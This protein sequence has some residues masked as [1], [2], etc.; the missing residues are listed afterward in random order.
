M[1][2]TLVRWY[3]GDR[4]LLGAALATLAVGWALAFAWAPPDRFQGDVQRL[5]YVHVPAAWSALALFTVSFLASVRVLWKRSLAADRLAHA[6][7]EVG[8]LFT[9]LT[10]A[11]GS[12]WGKP[13]WGVWWT[14]DPRLT[15][16]AILFV[17]FAGYLALRRMFD[18]PLRRAT[19]S[20]AVAI[21]AFADVPIVHWSVTWWE[22]LHQGPTVAR[23]GEP[24]LDG[25]MLATLLVNALAVSLLAGWLVMRRIRLARLEATA[26]DRL[27]RE[28]LAAASPLV[29][30]APRDLRG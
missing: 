26:E 14:W 4:A 10:L 9:A 25:A 24:A 13:V 28:R 16:T 19:V 20:A 5:M 7:V 1:I 22:G 29:A 2:R 17:L 15:T 3:P 23:L 21:V 30:I 8:L 18:D 6:A 27:L 11:S 12:L